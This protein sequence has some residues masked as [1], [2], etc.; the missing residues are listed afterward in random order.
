MYDAI[1]KYLCYERIA[2]VSVTEYLL[3]SHFM[4]TDRKSRELNHYKKFK[5]KYFGTEPYH[6]VPPEILVSKLS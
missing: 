3:T 6:N 2:Y 5:N 1:T 4:V